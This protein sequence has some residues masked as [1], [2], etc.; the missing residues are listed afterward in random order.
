MPDAQRSIF[1]PGLR[2]AGLFA[3]LVWV[4][5]KDLARHGKYGFVGEGLQQWWKKVGFH[6]HVAV[7]QDHDVIFRR[8]KAGIR[9]AAESKVAIES[10]HAHGREVFAQ[11]LRAAV[12]RAVIH[13]DN[14][15]VRIA[16]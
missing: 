13:D 8:A 6:A 4:A 15:V 7:Q 14:F 9:S 5:E 12:F 10:Q 3:Q 16:G 2:Q 11:E 1:P